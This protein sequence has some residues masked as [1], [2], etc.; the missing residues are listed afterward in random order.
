MKPFT[1]GIFNQK[2]IPEPAASTQSVYH[3]LDAV[4]EAVLTDQNANIQQ[5][6]DQAQQHRA[7]PDQPGQVAAPRTGGRS[8]SP[9][10]RRAAAPTEA[11]AH[12]DGRPIDVRWEDS[13][14]ARMTTTGLDAEARPRRTPLT[15]VRGG[16]LTTLLFLLPML[17]VFGAFSWYPIVAHGDHVAAAHEPRAAGDL[18][19]ASTTSAP[20]S[21][22]RCCRSRSRTPL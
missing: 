18:G 13:E 15:W 1:T 17:L 12:G 4:V 3:S 22:I 16:G 14:P 6:L 10:A 11:H 7:G 2:L 9:A 8:A 21:T 20:C 19:R 5:L